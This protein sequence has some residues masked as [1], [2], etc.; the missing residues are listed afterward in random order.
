MWGNGMFPYWAARLDSTILGLK[1]DGGWVT[2]RS[3][4]RYEM[5]P[6][7]IPSDCSKPD[8]T[9]MSKA[10][11]WRK[12]STDNSIQFFIIYVLCQQL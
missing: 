5:M 2:V 7:V 8:T 4:E 11:L 12:H 10:L 6:H 9:Y 3:N 1:W